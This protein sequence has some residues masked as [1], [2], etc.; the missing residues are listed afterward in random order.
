MIVILPIHP[1]N[2]P[3]ISADNS[4]HSWKRRLA[5]PV[6]DHTDLWDCNHVSTCS[7]R[8]FQSKMFDLEH[9]INAEFG[10]ADYLT[11]GK[12]QLSWI[13]FSGLF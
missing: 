3:R 7:Y 1:V 6:L 9:E 4:G 2:P 13:E 12:T 11:F 5:A 8:Y 10:N